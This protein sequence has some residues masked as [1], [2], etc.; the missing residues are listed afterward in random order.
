MR[1]TEA[2]FRLSNDIAEAIAEAIRRIP[3]FSRMSETRQSVFIDM[4]HQMGVHG[5]LGFHDMI[6]AVRAEDWAKAAVELLDS[7]Y[8]RED[9][10]ARAQRNA[11]LLEEG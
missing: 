5:V 4:I 2:E 3:G 8:A 6:R 10:P 1:L 11:R 9:A 7:K